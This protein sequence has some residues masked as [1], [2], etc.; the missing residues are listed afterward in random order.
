MLEFFGALLGLIYIY[1]EYRASIHLWVV[2]AV[3]PIVYAVVYFQA[4][5]YAQGCL[6]LYYVAAAI[7]GWGMW[8]KRKHFGEDEDLDE[9]SIRSI[10]FFDFRRYL[11]VGMLLATPIAVLQY[12]FPGAEIDF[13]DAFIAGLSIVA[14]WML[15]KKIAE[16]WLMWLIV[17]MTCVIYYLHLSVSTETSLYATAGLYGV[18]SI[19]AVAGYFKW[20]SI[21]EEQE[22]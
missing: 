4:D 5:L 3:M 1:L 10:S 21:A 7:Y 12:L 14:L 15:S 8:K 13:V 18:Y 17:D 2:G 20:K 6:Q 9:A 11:L 19:L 16:Q 22:E